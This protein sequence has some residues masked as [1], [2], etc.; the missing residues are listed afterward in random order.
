MS[1]KLLTTIALLGVALSSAVSFA[2]QA[3]APN[4]ADVV[5]DK[6]AFDIPYGTPITLD[7][8]EAAIAAA[9]AESKKRG[10]KMNVAVV[11]SGGNLVAFQRMDGAQLAS[12]VISEHKARAAANFR[13][14]TKVFENGINLN[15]LNSIITLDGVIASRGGIPLVEGG[16]LIGAIGCSGGSGA[17]DEVVCRVGV[18]T[19]K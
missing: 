10:W 13:R 14:E 15:N 8:A 16:R 2:Q 6:M 11:D 9:V 1:P 18:A 12:I 7:R 3:A 4:P 5:A 19:V 17:Q